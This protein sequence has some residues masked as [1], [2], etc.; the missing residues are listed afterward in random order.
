LQGVTHTAC[1]FEHL[2]NTLAA[3]WGCSR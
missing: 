2:Q 3:T 1:N